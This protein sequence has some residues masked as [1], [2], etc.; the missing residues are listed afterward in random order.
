[1]VHSVSDAMNKIVSMNG[2]NVQFSDILTR[3]MTEQGIITVTLPDQTTQ[4]L[5][6]T[7]EIDKQLDGKFDKTGGVVG[8]KVTAEGDVTS[9]MGTYL[10]K[11]ETSRN[12][13][14]IV[15]SEDDRNFNVHILQEKSGTL[16]HVG[17]FG[18]GKTSGV[19]LPQSGVVVSDYRINGTAYVYT[20]GQ[21]SDTYQKEITLF[22]IFLDM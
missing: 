2:A 11:L 13:T 10:V 5:R 12:K 8:G 14:S 7:K 6:T 21:G 3:W 17:D 22:L 20:S 1:M 4:Q 15:S 16:M 9:K 18:V 19:M